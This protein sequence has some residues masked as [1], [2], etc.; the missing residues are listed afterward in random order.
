[1]ACVLG[2]MARL[3][4]TSTRAAMIYQHATRDRDEAI[5]KAL[6]GLLHQVQSDASTRPA[7][8]SEK[9]RLARMWPG[10]R[11]LDASVIPPE[12]GRG[13]LTLGFG[14]ARSSRLGLSW[15]KRR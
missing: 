4:H 1:M 15:A 11:V 9:R 5:A 14:L 2:V 8:T 12:R 3:G 6:G 13:A 10:R 7:A